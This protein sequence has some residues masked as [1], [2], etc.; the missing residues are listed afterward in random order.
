MLEGERVAGA[1]VDQEAPVQLHRPEQGGDCNGGRD[2]RAQRP[3]AQDRLLPGVE[4]AG[5][6]LQRDRQLLESLRQQLDARHEGIEDRAGVELRR[7]RAAAQEVG[8]GKRPRPPE[9]SEHLP[10]L[11]VEGDGAV[12]HVAAGEA[13]RIA[14][15]DDRADRRSGDQR[16]L[17]A[18]LVEGFAD[19]DM[20]HAAGAAAA[21]R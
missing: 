8:E 10:P 12:A 21:E 1:A 20:R 3:A 5:D 16:R 15:A 18:E 17:D 14:G 2:R 6:D 19:Q 9:P 13:G 7:Q 11:G 4:I